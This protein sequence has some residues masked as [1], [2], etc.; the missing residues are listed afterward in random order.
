VTEAT[1]PT[2][3]T[4]VLYGLSFVL[5]LVAGA[6]LGASVLDELQDTTILWVSASFSVC[7]AILAVLALLLPRRSA[8]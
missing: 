3:L 4:L 5:M 1:G 6:V 2:R 8:G 7:A